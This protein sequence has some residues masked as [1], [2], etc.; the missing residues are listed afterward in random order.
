MIEVDR[1]L[2]DSLPLAAAPLRRV[3]PLC[4]LCNPLSFPRLVAIDEREPRPVA[5]VR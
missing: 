3:R 4:H 2:A 5:T 1:V